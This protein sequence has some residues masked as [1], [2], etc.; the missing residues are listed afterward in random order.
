L[1][2]KVAPEQRLF[3][4]NTNRGEQKECRVVYVKKE[5]AGPTKVAVEFKG[6]APSFW[7]IAYLPADWVK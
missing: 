4:Q 7:R 3:L 2:K 5:S 6:S 1:W